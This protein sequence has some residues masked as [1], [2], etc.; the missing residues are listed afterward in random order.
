MH[1]LNFKKLLTALVWSSSVL[2]YA[3]PDRTVTLVVPTAAGGG[4]DAM[5]RVIAQKMA[6]LLGQSVIVENKAGA[7][8]SIATEFV[9]RASADGHTVLFGYVATHAMNPALQKLRYDPVGDFEP[10]GLVGYSPTLMVVTPQLKAADAK[11]VLA[12]IQAQDG[13]L[14]Y[15][16]AGNGTAPH[17]A[18]ELYKLNMKAS[19]M[20]VPYKGSAPAVN[21]TVA[22]HTHIMFPSLFTALPH[23][24]SGKLHPVGIAGSRRSPALPGVPTLKELGVPGVDVTQWYALFVPAKTPKAVVDR[25]NA[26]LNQVLTDKDT[27]ARIEAQGADV[28][29]STPEEL[30]TLVRDDLAKWRRVVHQA[31][32]SA[33]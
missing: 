6:P 17:F 28:Q 22:G 30:K 13:K 29:T 5:A 11:T 8:G 23:V 21:D 7:N 2:A 32:L 1:P 18:A 24:K 19:W 33:D 12:S 16:S 15:A 4:N 26:A 9:A 20:H 31:K 3:Y 14:S 10:V 25:L 27:V